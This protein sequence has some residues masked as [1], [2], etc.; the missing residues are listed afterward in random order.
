MK[1][2]RA[3][4]ALPGAGLPRGGLAAARARQALAGAPA[5]R[6]V[7][8]GLGTVFKLCFGAAAVVAL[9][10]FLLSTRVALT[11]AL[12]SGMVAVLLDHAVEALVHRGLRRSGAIVVV[13]LA[14]TVV[15]TGL[16]LL[17]IPPVVEQA[18]ALVAAAPE[19]WAR[20]QHTRW[21]LRLDGWLHLQDQLRASGA[22][23][24]GAVNPVLSA[25]GGAI[26]ALAGL[27]GSLFLAL[28]M[29]VFGRALVAGALAEL[30]P[31]WRERARRVA[32]RIYRSVGGY[33]AGLLGI[34]TVNAILTTAFLAAIQVPFF[35][36][37]GVVSGASS[38]V[39]YVGPLVVGVAITLFALA[40]GGVWIGAAAAIYF[41]VYGQLEGNVLAPFVYRRTAHVN[42][43]V[44]LL[45]MLFLAELMG[46]VGAVVAVPVA[47]AAQVFV[48]EILVM[49]REQAS[50]GGD[51]PVHRP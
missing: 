25:I 27:L 28:S 40:A 41:A 21:F 39:P 32:G 2:P 6:S 3:P 12:G 47:A 44:T 34:C 22:A 36:P 4:S 48:A 19:L 1:F 50:P 9:A 31:A 51:P 35:L 29:L 8:V 37:L 45:A 14:A 30:S 24:V 33:L 16:G 11:L 10:S 5:R 26:T 23:A 46:T 7:H 42:Q 13:M 17:L 15:L 49:R 18:A 43:L 20:L 38:L